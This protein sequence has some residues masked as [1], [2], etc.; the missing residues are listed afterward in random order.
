[1]CVPIKKTPNETDFI[2][3]S[4]TS[5][6]P[7]IFHRLIRLLYENYNETFWQYVEE[8]K[9]SNY[10]KYTKYFDKDFNTF[11]FDIFS[12]S[13]WDIIEEFHLLKM[14][15]YVSENTI[16]IDRDSILND[17]LVIGFTLISLD[18]L[19]RLDEI[20]EYFQWIE[21]KTG[22]SIEIGEIRILNH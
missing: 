19:E 18:E 15:D 9:K 3:E 7:R 14:P 5:P 2:I 10:K 16:P 21:Q 6:N 22:L 12:R 20:K 17:P 8:I 13:F 1:L 11:L 4:S